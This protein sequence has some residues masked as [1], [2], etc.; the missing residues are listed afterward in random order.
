MK[1]QASAQELMQYARKEQMAH[2]KANPAFGQTIDLAL[3]P[4]EQGDTL[5]RGLEKGVFR[6]E[7]AT[8]AEGPTHLRHIY[9][10]SRNWERIRGGS[11]VAV[12]FPLFAHTNAAGELCTAPLLTW[13]VHL[14]PGPKLNSPWV[15]SRMP[16]HRARLNPYLLAYWKIEF[17]KDLTEVLAP[18]DRQARYSRSDFHQ[19]GE[20]AAAALEL[21]EAWSWA[22]EL[23]PISASASPS[24]VPKGQ[25]LASA[26]L[27]LFPHD[28]P[29]T[30]GSATAAHHTPNDREHAFGPLVLDP[31]QAT[32]AE[33]LLQSGQLWLEGHAGTGK[34]A[35]GVHLLV[36]Q[37]AQG[38]P[39]L[40]V[41]SRVGPL[42]A[43]EQ[44]L[45]K[46]KLGRLAFLLRDTAADKLLMLDIIRASV[47]HSAPVGDYNPQVFRQRVAKGIR[48]HKKLRESYRAYRATTLAEQQWAETVGQYLESAQAEGK[49]LLGTQLNAQDYSFTTEAYEAL[50]EAVERCY[51]LFL[52]THTLRSPLAKLNPGLFL[53]MEEPEAKDFA[54]T[55]TRQFLGKAK[56]LQLWYINR[57][58]AYADQLSAHYEQHYQKL[59]RKLGQLKDTLAEHSATFGPAFNKTGSGA[60]RVQKLFSDRARRLQAA[61]EEVSEAYAQLREDFQRKPY[62]EFNLPP[63]RNG[64]LEG[65]EPRLRSF[66]ERL[67][68]WRLS[69]R[70]LVQEEV[71]RLSHKSANAQLG[72]A[73]QVRELEDSL[74]RLLEELNET[75]LYYLPLH[76][77]TLTIPKRQRFLEEVIEQ[78][79]ETKRALADFDNFY[80]WQRNWLELDEN[81]RR[82]IKALLKVRPGDWQA[83][84]RTWFLDNLLNDRY[85]AVLPPDVRA[86]EDYADVMEH[87]RQQLQPHI[88]KTWEDKKADSAQ[89]L[90]RR[91]RA[92]HKWL[93]QQEPIA[94][95]VVFEQQFQALGPLPLSTCPVML[96]VPQLA[97]DLFGEGQPSFGLVIVEEA[98]LLSAA[99]LERLSALGEKALFLSPMGWDNQSLQPEE[100]RSEVP[101]FQ[102]RHAHAQAPAHLRQATG[103][104]PAVRN[105]GYFHFEQVDGTY[106][107]ALER[108]EAEAR[109]TLALLTQIEQTPQRTY[110]SVGIVAMTR[111][112]RQLLAE[113]LL[114]IKQRRSNGVEIIQQLER[115]GLTLMDLSEVGGQK[116]DI[117]ILSAT[118]GPVGPNGPVSGHFHRLDN[119][120][121]Q[122]RIEALMSS[123]QQQ[124]WVLNS[125]PS[126]W[127]EEA[128]AKAD[129]HQRLPAFLAY[130]SACARRDIP[131]IEQLTARYADVF[132]QAP[133]FA[134][135][136]T[137]LRQVSSYLRPYLSPGRLQLSER[138]R[139]EVPP[140]A[141]EPLPGYTQ[142]FAL[143][144]DG[145]L[146]HT[147]DTSYAWEA[148]RRQALQAEGVTLEN[149]ASPDW[150]RN[151]ELQARRLASVLLQGEP[152]PKL[153]RVAEE[154]E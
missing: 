32:A 146:A 54:S 31:Y 60:L 136:Y 28:L 110:P 29:C 49:E 86:I 14:E 71:G 107:E 132:E 104:E 70:E 112:Q 121:A 118:F 35:L 135:P 139:L 51:Q 93:S 75:G 34:T 47:K 27:G 3:L 82:L 153:P 56:R 74:D 111:G 69:L 68:R 145:F 9:Y 87:L 115:N 103:P 81:A 38:K 140:L 8:G 19:L 23:Q 41:S 45:D 96:T 53:R 98:E 4:D 144:T 113:H 66:E 91:N 101:A 97:Q 131:Q 20:A 15:V 134:P 142:R 108:N 50:G 62:F 147:P 126:D 10:E 6:Q 129:R 130:L 57:Q 90:R 79:E 39:C 73:D 119:A 102:L 148:Q 77:K 99:T 30:A 151:P 76:N 143:L 137:L 58:D 17:G 13:E 63:L 65:L 122:Q 100:A 133:D 12:G 48:L 80:A 88:L 125:L 116:F 124:I 5:L 92:A 2:I 95:P 55:H 61:R 89:R 154:E 59:A 22:G 1:M 64:Q 152:Q 117:L 42:R 141:I 84:Y 85:E 21:E 18:Y 43:Y 150:W 26:V 138:H 36:S 25:L 127:L 78:L 114:G 24:G 52:K 109:S 120:Q 94:D 44:A 40:V 128:R 7:L 105:W 11:A 46:L 33:Q 123:A 106:D 149:I 83:A 67:Q 37:L 72:F 16:T